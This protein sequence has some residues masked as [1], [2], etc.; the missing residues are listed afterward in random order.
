MDIYFHSGGKKHLEKYF[1]TI[2]KLYADDFI[3]LNDFPPCRGCLS[4]AFQEH[5]YS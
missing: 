2:S 3:S 5:I 1:L 4:R